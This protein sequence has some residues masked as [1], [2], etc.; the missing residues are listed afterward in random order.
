MII[1]VLN[2]VACSGK[3]EFIK[4]FTEI[5]KNKVFNISTVDQVKNIAKTFFGWCGA[6][7]DKSRKFLSELKRIWL[8]FNNGP[9]EYTINEISKFE[10]NSKEKDVVFIHCREIP[11]IKK[12]KEYYKGY[13]FITLL[14]KRN[15][16]VPNNLSDEQVFDYEYDYII[17]N[18]DDLKQLKKNAQKFYKFILNK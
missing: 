2:G 16:P 17:D 9:F 8:E 1:I 7:D 13:F 4:L 10:I 11:E 12:F 15:V 14:V 5:T 18:N 6:K 3:D